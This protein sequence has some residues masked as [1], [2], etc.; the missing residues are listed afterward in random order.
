MRKFV[1]SVALAAVAVFL[2]FA[3]IGPANAATYDFVYQTEVGFP[4]YTMSGVLTTSNV[5]N[6]G[7]PDGY[8]ISA[9]TGTLLDPA[10][11]TSNLSL[12]AGNAVPPSFINNPSWVDYDN[13]L[14]PGTG[15]TSTGG[16]LM[17]STNGIPV[18]PVA[19]KWSVRQYR[20]LGILVLK[21]RAFVRLLQYSNGPG[22]PGTLSI[23]ET[24][25]PSTWTMLIAAFAG[26]GF[27]AYRG[28]KKNTPALA[29]A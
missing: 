22:E 4:S 26:F 15:V 12:V 10:S 17:Q 1:A 18:Q 11:A 9:I 27:L 3:A 5:L 21:R 2:G 13:S 16:W 24:P 25:L 19:W 8:D 6:G 14:I 20:W 28:T 29:V 23:S 7:T